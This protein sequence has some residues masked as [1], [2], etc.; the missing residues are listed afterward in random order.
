ML[1]LVSHDRPRG[2]HLTVEAFDDLEAVGE[3]FRDGARV[4]AEL[5]CDD[6]MAR[7]AID[8][9]SGLTYA[10]DGRIEAAAQR[11]FLLTPREPGAAATA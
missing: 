11:V 9:M 8:F 6:S 5:R 7:R 2:E 3:A 4:T 1:Q 10:L